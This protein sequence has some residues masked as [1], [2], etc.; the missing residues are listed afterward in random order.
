MITNFQ[1]I[2][3]HKSVLLIGIGATNKYYME[4]VKPESVEEAEK[5]FGICN[6]TDS[7]ILL[8]DGHEDADIFILN[9]EDVHDYLDAARLLRSYRFSYIVP[10]D[11][12]LSSHFT[13]PTA[14][15]MKTY[16]L[17]YLLNQSHR[18]NSSIILATDQHAELYE[19]V[20]AYLDEMAS[21]LQDFKANTVSNDQKENIVFAAN[22]ILGVSYANV[23]L[24][25]MILNSEVNEY[26][27]ETKTRKAVFDIDRTD[28]VLD[29]AYFRNHADGTMTVENLLNLSS[30][31]SP[32]KIF[33]F[34]R[35]CVF[36]GR[37]MSFED[38]V[39]STYSVYRKQQIAQEID[40]YL[41]RLE[42]LL[43]TQYKIDEV[44]AEED[45]LHPGSVRIV[46]K[47]SIRPV[48]CSERFIQRTV[49]A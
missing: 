32:I 44:Y 22:N 12:Y 33:T 9:I 17:Q 48:G 43:I 27:Y 36:I 23:I 8:H 13:D 11:V 47:Y 25:R 21:R 10:I 6:L 3:K 30:G 31:Q 34:Y 46:V 49:I 16:Y 35:I 37:E 38:Y 29:M 45:I 14:D 20:D 19:N 1:K 4:I 26:P 7:Y 18:D 15:T 2:D 28:K 40:K 24:A 5:A 39:G 42:G 41:G